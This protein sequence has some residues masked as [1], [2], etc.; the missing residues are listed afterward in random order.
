MNLER[1]RYVKLL[2]ER[3]HLRETAELVGLSAGALSRSVRALEDELG[4]RVFRLVGKRLVLTDEGRRLLP[5]AERL[6]GEYASFRQALA[7][8]AP[9]VAPV[10]F[11]SHSVFTT[12]FLGYVLRHHAP[13]EEIFARHLVP[14][15]IEA[16]IAA[17]ESDFGLTYLPVPTTGIEFIP[18]T[19]V[20]MGIFARRGAFRGVPFDQIPCSIPLLRVSDAAPHAVTVDAWPEGVPRT[21]VRYH[22]DLLETALEACRQGLSWG[23]FPLFV[24][25]LHNAEVR[26]ELAIEPLRVAP[27]PSRRNAWQVFLVK[28][29]GDE[30][31]AA[32]KRTCAALRVV[33]KRAAAHFEGRSGGVA[34]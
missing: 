22:F 26:K 21:F 15:A 20:A 12:Y 11:A 28:R 13:S 18:V 25:W 5:R 34:R 32:M 2:A 10:R 29:G 31:S 19:R 16:S 23:Y 9:E 30:E 24:A 14:G 33:C 7:E 17:R 8:G 6:L 27:S 3:G 4:V 1:L